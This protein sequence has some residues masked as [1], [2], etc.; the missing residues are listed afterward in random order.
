MRKHA[1]NMHTNPTPNPDPTDNKSD[2]LPVTKEPHQSNDFGGGR[3][4]G[5]TFHMT[6]FKFHL[7]SN[8]AL[9]QSTE[10]L[11]HCLWATRHDGLIGPSVAR[12]QEASV[13]VAESNT[14]LL[15]W[16][17]TAVTNWP[18]PEAGEHLILWLSRAKSSSFF[19][20]LL[21]RIWS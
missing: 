21:H 15:S 1:L 19:P 6:A 9:L 16:Y 7:G 18:I 10:S 14:D 8:S 4:L 12:M 3:S 20:L 2:H 13:D 11:G 17:C 5:W